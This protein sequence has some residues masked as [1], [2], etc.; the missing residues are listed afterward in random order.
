MKRSFEHGSIIH[1]LIV[2]ARLSASISK[3]SGA[4]DTAKFELSGDNDTAKFDL[5]VS[6]ALLLSQD[7][8]VC[9][10]ICNGEH[11]GKFAAADKMFL[12]CES[13]ALDEI[14]DEKTKMF[15]KIRDCPF[16]SNICGV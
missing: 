7:S 16:I 15:E 1:H 3:L 8:A 13:A 4:N 2:M 5:G 10:A 11:L 14:F 12:G 9:L 6:T